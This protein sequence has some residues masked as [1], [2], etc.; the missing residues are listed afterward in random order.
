MGEQANKTMLDLSK[1][2]WKY[3]LINGIT[4]TAE[5]L[6]NFLDVT[7]NLESRNTKD[8]SEWKL[9]PTI[10]QQKLGLPEIDLFA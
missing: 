5:Y 10:F 4:I 2:I 1:D 9:C 8:S 7:A 3:L 6:P